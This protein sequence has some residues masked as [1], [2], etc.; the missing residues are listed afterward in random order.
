MVLVLAGLATAACSSGSESAPLG[1][2]QPVV[3]TDYDTDASTE[4]EVTVLAVRRGTVAELEAAGLQFDPEEEDLVPHYVD[5]RFTNTGTET[6]PRTMRVSLEDSND[7]LISPTIVFDF[8]GGQTTPE[9]PCIDVKDGELPPGESFED[10]TLFLV[11]PAT[12][13]AA[14]TFLSAPGSSESAF[15]D[16]ALE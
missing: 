11:D 15:V 8:S 1:T 5:V 2:A 7:S 13:V 4:L 12:D 6:V 10:C 14:V 16:W 3:H 9:G